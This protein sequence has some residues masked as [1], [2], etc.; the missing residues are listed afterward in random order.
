M[1]KL[2]TIIAAS[3]LS[4]GLASPVQAA[5][6][7]IKWKMQSA[8]PGGLVQ[9]G[10]SGKYFASQLE[11]ISGG[12]MKVKFYEPNA[13]VPAL[14]I[15]GAVQTGSIDAGWAAA[16]FWAGKVPAASFFGSVPFGP[17]AG[18]YMA[19]LSYGGGQE[20]WD[21][22]Y[23]PLGVKGIACGMLAPESS[24]WFRKEI[25][26]LTDLKGLKMRFYG[27]GAK[28]ME[29]HGVS[30]QLMAPGDIFPALE[31]GTLDATEFSQP[32]IDL[33][34]GFYQVAKHYYFPGWHQQAS[35]LE[36]LVNLEKWNALS[37]TQRSQ[38][39]TVCSANMQLTLAEGEAIQFDALATLEE[40]GVNIHSWSNEILAEL[41]KSWNEVVVEESA[42]NAD[43]K[44]V[45]DSLSA[46]RAKYSKW[47]S[48][49]YLK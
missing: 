45:W 16:G 35:L 2:S 15:L 24:G 42:E 43:F 48:V 29:K 23:K 32:A 34:L 3:L 44:R 49:G 10:A 41:Q 20:I 8:Y 28:V 4:I 40:K 13:L 26:S 31:R 27:L 39:D 22:L 14:E 46:F 6:S 37:D 19:W 25:K 21:E 18:E 12:N 17:N 1:T 30:T 7:E 36:L 33:K 11:V 38:I 47:N 5:D 9:L